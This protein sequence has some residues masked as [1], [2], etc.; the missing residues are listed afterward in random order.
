[1]PA[2]DSLFS[3]LG[4]Q[5]RWEFVADRLFYA[6][7]AVAP[8]SLLVLT[9]AIPSWSKGIHVQLFSALSLVIWQPLVEELLF[10]GIIQGQLLKLQ[11][12]KATVLKLSVANLLAS[13]LFMLAHLAFHSPAWAA[14]VWVP[15]LVFG[16]FRDRY[17]HILPS[18]VLHAAYNAMY[19]FAG[20]RLEAM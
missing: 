12:A 20:A 4:L 18:L 13:F 17:R 14:A 11:W 10:R 2:P 19:L 7:L 3:E 8:I 1:M 15:S 16:Y 9:W 6:A 5:C